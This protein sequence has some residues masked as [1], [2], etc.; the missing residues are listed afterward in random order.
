MKN[1]KTYSQALLES[2][3]QDEL[4]NG[5]LDAARDGNLEEVR[6]LIDRG[7]RVDAEDN[8]KRTPLHRA[9]WRGQAEVAGLLIDRGARVDAED[10]I[11]WTPLHW[12]AAYDRTEVM[13]LLLDRGANVDAEDAAKQ[14][15]L[16][17]AAL[18]G[19]VEV[20]G[21]L[22]DRGADPFK[23]FDGLDEIIEFFKG[24]ISWMPEELKAK[25]ERRVRSRGAFGS[26]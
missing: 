12:A 11:K 17:F 5:L 6:S 15:P 21:L 23:A 7:A 20:A 24:D 16:H 22:I 8:I 26:F 9:A 1:I 3:D 2:S 25:V 19:H 14:T 4:N 18:H 13:R 10:N